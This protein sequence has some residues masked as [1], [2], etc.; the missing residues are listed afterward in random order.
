[1]T[2]AT[3]EAPLRIL[4]PTALEAWAARR[5]LRG[6]PIERSGVGLSR[7]LAPDD[8][9]VIVLCGL[10]GAL[11]ADLLPGSVVVPSSVGLPDGRHFSCHPGW[12][13]TFAAAAE[14]LGLPVDTG[15]MLTAASIV[16]GAERATWAAHGYRAADME[17]GLLLAQGRQAATVRVILDTPARS[18]SDR[19]ERALQAF[20]RPRLWEELLWM[21]RHA[22]GY[23][24]LA[25][26]IVR[27]AL[28]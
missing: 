1:V 25:A 21:G 6:W 18:I 10:A 28:P 5:E 15:P 16:T 24:R 9:S 23:A 8:G 2:T 12:V 11:V 3:P 19:W 13:E 4:A 22:P 26:R 14:R 17:T 20:W 27:E 7:L